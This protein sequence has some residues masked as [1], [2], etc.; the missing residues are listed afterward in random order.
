MIDH[1]SIQ[2]E[3]PNLP[4]FTVALDRMFRRH[5]TR[6]EGIGDPP[7]KVPGVG[8]LEHEDEVVIYN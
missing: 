3:S 8:K 2:G 4:S 6:C 1:G 5:D 7:L